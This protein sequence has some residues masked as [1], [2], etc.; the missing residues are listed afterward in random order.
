VTDGEAA[1]DHVVREMPPA[2]GN[3]ET[4]PSDNSPLPL[5]APCFEDRPVEP[6]PPEYPQRLP[7]PAPAQEP[8]M[9]PPPPASTAMPA[10]RSVLVRSPAA[11]VPARVAMV[12]AEEAP[13]P[14]E[15]ADSL[16]DAQGESERTSRHSRRT[17]R[18]ISAAAALDR[19]FRE[20]LAAPTISKIPSDGQP[21]CAVPR[22]FPPQRAPI[23]R[24]AI[25]STR[26][27]P[28][29]GPLRQTQPSRPP[30]ASSDQQSPANT[31]IGSHA[32]T[33]NNDLPR[34]SMIGIMPGERYSAQQNQ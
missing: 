15:P 26:R 4:Q 17:T 3:R 27:P 29:Y 34:V 12:D 25:R 20:S 19:R 23:P 13:S 9:I 18:R 21:I 31:D 30:R 1:M 2:D 22:T 33:C 16:A 32:S 14:P 11:A 7:A 6:Q 5:D 10:V 8:E 24:H 28:N